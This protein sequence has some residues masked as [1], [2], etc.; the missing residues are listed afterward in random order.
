VNIARDIQPLTY[1]RRQSADVVKRLKA[2]RRPMILTI[3]GKA[4]LVVQDAASYQRLLDIAAQADAREGI[5]Q[6][7]EDISRG[8]TRSSRAV[9]DD[10]RAK[11]DIPR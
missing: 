6:G 4:E 2:T 5:R 9:F 10:L 8:R 11:Y 3:N 1:F 7:M